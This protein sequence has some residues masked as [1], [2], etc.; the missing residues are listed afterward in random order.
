MRNRQSTRCKSRFLSPRLRFG[1]RNDKRQSH[2]MNFNTA[3]FL[4]PLPLIAWAFT[5]AGLAA[6]F[7][8]AALLPLLYKAGKL[9][10]DKVD[11]TA[12]NDVFLLGVW[13]LSFIGGM[14]MLSYR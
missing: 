1:M 6:L 5:V 7:I 2:G 4:L 11:Y 8:G 9:P 13:S 10:S 3:D 14:G 12:W